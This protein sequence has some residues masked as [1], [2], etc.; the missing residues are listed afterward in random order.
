MSHWA[1]SLIGKPYQRGAGGPDAFDCW[2]L[3]CHVFAVRWGIEM[4]AVAI[5]GLFTEAPANVA[6]IKRVAQ[7]SGWAPAAPPAADADIV[8]MHGLEGRH[9][10]VMIEVDGALRL[11]HCIEGAGVCAQ[12]LPEAQMQGF[13][14]FEFWRR[15]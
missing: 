15:A 14:G 13:W 3:V 9:V 2:G 1:S 7:V 5:G 8:L 12:P 11:L 6:A 4:P 10:G